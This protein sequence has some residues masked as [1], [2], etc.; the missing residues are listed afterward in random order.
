MTLDQIIA[1]LDA[2]APGA[3][4]VYEPSDLKDLDQDDRNAL[5]VYADML[6]LELRATHITG[7]NRMTFTKPA[8]RTR[9]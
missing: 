2:L 8:P 7:G 6:E 1:N 3:A 4:V 9:R 5:T